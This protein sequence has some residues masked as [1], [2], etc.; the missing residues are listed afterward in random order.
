MK[1]YG[2]SGRGGVNEAENERGMYEEEGRRE[3]A[4]EV[5]INFRDL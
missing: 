4:A 1:K 5:G 3:W 2:E